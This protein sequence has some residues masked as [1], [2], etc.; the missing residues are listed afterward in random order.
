MYF[1]L[2]C[3]VVFLGFPILVGWANPSEAQ[4]PVRPSAPA[5][6]RLKTNAPAMPRRITLPASL[7]QLRGTIHHFKI[8]PPQLSLIPGPGQ[9]PLLFTCHH[10]TTYQDLAGKTLDPALLIPE[11]PVLVVFTPGQNQLVAERVVAQ[12]VQLIQPGGRAAWVTGEIVR[13][14]S[15]EAL[16]P[17]IPAAAQPAGVAPARPSG[18]RLKQRP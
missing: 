11:T 16:R 10:A 1:F 13:N 17:G 12:Q 6:V 5:G 7:P 8:S 9:A 3:S 4:P 2:K 14:G 18:L 15:A